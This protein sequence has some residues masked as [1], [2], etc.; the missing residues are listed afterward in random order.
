MEITAVDM[1]PKNRFWLWVLW[2][3]GARTP[4]SDSEYGERLAR[5]R[6]WSSLPVMVMSIGVFTLIA[7]KIYLVIS[8]FLN[9]FNSLDPE[10]AV[11][12]H[13]LSTPVHE[14]VMTSLLSIAHEVMHAVPLALTIPLLILWL[15]AFVVD[16]IVAATLANNKKLWWKR[17]WGGVI[18]ALITIP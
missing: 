3:L 13:S 2:A 12:S 6:R 15:L 10:T 7:V 18:T 9:A 4:S 17:H 14:L 16:F 8:A 1:K 11:N 5:Y